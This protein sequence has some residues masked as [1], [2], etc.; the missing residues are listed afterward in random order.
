M[1]L[2]LASFHQMDGI[3]F[4]D[5][6]AVITLVGRRAAQRAGVRHW[7]RGA[8]D[9]V[10]FVSVSGNSCQRPLLALPQR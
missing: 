5:Y 9:K 2:M 1:P 8:D 3:Q 6:S 10:V 7:R 4:G